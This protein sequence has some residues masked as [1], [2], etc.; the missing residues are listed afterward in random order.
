[1][2]AKRKIEAAIAQHELKFGAKSRRVTDFGS[3]GV[4]LSTMLIKSSGRRRLYR[5]QSF[6][7]ASEEVQVAC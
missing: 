7:K 5:R 1:V 2:R 4:M 3:N 6:L